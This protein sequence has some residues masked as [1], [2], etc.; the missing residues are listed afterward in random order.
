MG[1]AQAA[2]E[3][4]Q[5]LKRLGVRL[6]IDDFGTGY[7]SLSYLQKLPVDALKL[8]QSFVGRLG[9]DARSGPLVRAVVEMGNALGMEV[10]A[11]G[12]ET[13][14]QLAYLREVG[15]RTGQGRYFAGALTAR[16]FRRLAASRRPAT[17]WETLLE[18]G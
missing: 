18:A 16:Q 1:D 3:A 17:A 4:L 7:S 11:E 8:D 14:W 6:A 2:M 10:V 5:A 13:E 12:I 9:G 15:C